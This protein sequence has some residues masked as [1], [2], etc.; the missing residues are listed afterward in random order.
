MPFP[1]HSRNQYISEF[2]KRNLTENVELTASKTILNQMLTYSLPSSG[3]PPC[4]VPRVHTAKHDLRYHVVFLHDNTT[5]G[6][7][8]VAV[9][10]G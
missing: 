5:R 4:H 9:V 10:H 2:P 3:K 1:N 8:H 7:A 6:I